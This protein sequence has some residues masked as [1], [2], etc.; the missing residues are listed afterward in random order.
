[1][2]ARDVCVQ[3]SGAAF[4]L[5]GDRNRVGREAATNFE[6]AG[7]FAWAFTSLVGSAMNC[8]LEIW[9]TAFVAA[10]F[11]VLCAREIRGRVEELPKD[12]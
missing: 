9:I 12:Q 7:W 5:E 10:L 8:D 3:A 11:V 2:Y 1:M 4:S 6:S